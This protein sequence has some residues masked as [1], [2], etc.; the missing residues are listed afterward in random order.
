M[1]GASIKIA[2]VY[3]GILQ[4]FCSISGA[5]INKRKSAIYGWNAD[6][7]AIQRITLS[8][9][10]LGFAS[11]DK[12]KYL[13]LP[14]TLGPNKLSMWKE[15]ISKINSKIIAWGGQWLTNARKLILIKSVLSSLPIYQA[16]FLL[17]PKKITEKISRLI[18]D[19]LW[20]GG[21]GNQIKF[22]LVNWDTVKLPISEGGLQ[23]RDPGLANLA[24]G[25]KILWTL[26]SNTKHLVS[27]VIKKKYLKGST[28]RNIQ[29]DNNIKG[30]SIWHLC[31]RGIEFFQKHLYRI[32]GNGKNTML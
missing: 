16:S 31:R 3:S 11:W 9:G 6:Q 2:K 15:V 24:L 27:Q 17:A 12:I 20:R 4:K 29:I 23:I 10:F 5:L 25:G 21:R 13:G 22:H 14:K 28:L 7:Q 18:K 26:F 8:L 30:T 32:P 19:F 1:G